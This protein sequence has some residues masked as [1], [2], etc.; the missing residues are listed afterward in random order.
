VAA[1]VRAAERS[2]RQLERLLDRATQLSDIITIENDLARRQAD[3]DSLKAQQAWLED[4]TS[5]STVNVYLSRPTH[6]RPERHEA[7]GF[8]A[9]LEDGWAA[10]KGAGLVTLT[11][12]GATLPFL[13]LLALVGVPV[14]MLVRRR[15]AL[16]PPPTAEA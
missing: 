8:L 16:V 12:L 2:I 14:W 1:R 10:M 7:R 13:V 15:R 5:L 6:G 3:L 11:V 4:Q 9:G